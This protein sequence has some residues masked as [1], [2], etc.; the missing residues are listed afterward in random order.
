MDPV[1][2]WVD[3]QEMRRL[4]EAL[5]SAPAKP[6]AAADD[7][8]FSGAFV[9]FAQG[10]VPQIIEPSPVTVAPAPEPVREVVVT[11]VPVPEPID[12]VVEE[13]L[14]RPVVTKVRGPF[15]E[16]LTH[17]REWLHKHGL[18]QG[19]FVLDKEGSVIFDDGDHERLHFMARSL[20]MAAKRSP[21]GFGHVQMKVGS[22]SLMEV[23]P[24]DTVYGLMVLG[25]LVEH[26]L[27]ALDIAPLSAALQR[28]VAPPQP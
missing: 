5:M 11:P 14:A 26:P 21:E 16:R 2:P 7:A 22:S 9:G 3:P 20:A 18:V 19:L 28:A 6:L 25:L 23:I 24:V 8:G 15:L 4:A 13:A 10:N 17:F 27:S 1:H 12:T